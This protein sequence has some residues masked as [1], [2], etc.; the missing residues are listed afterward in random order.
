MKRKACLPAGREAPMKEVMGRVVRSEAEWK[1][2]VEA[3]E[4]SKRSAA[5]FCREHG[6]AYEQFLYHR[7]RYLTKGEGALVV[8][9][10]GGGAPVVRRRGFLPV[11]VEDSCCVR[12]KFPRGLVLETDRIPS[13]A[14]V[15]EVAVRWVGAEVD[16]C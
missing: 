7:R 1:A 15:V 10:P 6:I 8:S 3:H 5:G 12:L 16:P 4:M 9:G 14:W 13:A 2:I 11:R